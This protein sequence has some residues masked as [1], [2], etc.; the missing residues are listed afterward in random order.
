MKSLCSLLT[1]VVFCP[2]WRIHDHCVKLVGKS[3]CLQ[4]AQ[5]TLDQIHVGNLKLLRISLECLQCV[6]VDVE[7][8]TETGEKNSGGF[9][10]KAE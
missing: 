2:E 6:V 8:D 9:G 4:R 3:F 1:L 7:A 10:K 5:V